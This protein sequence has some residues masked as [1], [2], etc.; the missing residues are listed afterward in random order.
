[1]AHGKP[2]D[3]HYVPQFYL[4]EFACDPERLKIHTVARNEDFAVFEERSIKNIGYDRDFYVHTKNG[5]PVNVETVINT[6]AETPL[7]SSETWRKISAGLTQD[8]DRSD[9][10]VIYSLI[11]H[12]ES[13]NPH[14]REMSRQLAELAANPDS[15]IP[16]TDE[17]REMHA[18]LRRHPEEF[19]AFMNFRAVQ[20]PW[21]ERDF[22]GSILSILRSPI[23]L[24]TATSPVLS[25]RA[26][27]H[28]ALHLPLPGQE[29]YMYVL[30]LNRTTLATL[31]LGDFD[32]AFS[33]S[34]M[35]L[36]VAKSVNRHFVV[37]FAKYE[38]VRHLIADDADLVADM[39]WAPYDLLYAKDGHM[40]FR[41]RPGT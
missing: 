28:P 22:H 25:V 36:E 37:Q 40:K 34:E 12:L 26:P 15:D 17:E 8:L 2:R 18:Y 7:S 14:A 29:P 3:H 24:R 33:N 35:P 9:K 30:T 10:G 38:H 27:D 41:R 4:K 11:R 20:M 23:A 39:I 21:S 32:G 13:R 19:R 1:M 16:F 31:A 6:A 5:A